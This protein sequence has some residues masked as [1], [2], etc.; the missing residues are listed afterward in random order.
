MSDSG[1]TVGEASL[2]TVVESGTTGNTPLIIAV[3][4]G[5]DHLKLIS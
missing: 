1:N 2:I 3:K 4:T 5:R